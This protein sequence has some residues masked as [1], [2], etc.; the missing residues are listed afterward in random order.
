MVNEGWRKQGSQSWKG[1]F[2]SKSGRVTK[3]IERRSKT[4]RVTEMIERRNIPS[5][6]K[7]L[8]PRVQVDGDDVEMFD[9]KAAV[10]KMLKQPQKERRSDNLDENGYMSAQ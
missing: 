2:A 7:D 8:P 5:F 4:E 9:R 10:L 1:S 6:A 3:R